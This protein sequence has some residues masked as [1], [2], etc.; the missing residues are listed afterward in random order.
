MPGFGRR[1]RRRRARPAGLAAL[2]CCGLIGAD[3][4]AFAV[5]AVSQ[6]PV[7]AVARP[8]VLITVVGAPEQL[9]RVRDALAEWR[10]GERTV[11]WQ[12]A[13]HFQP[14]ALFESHSEE[15]AVR[16]WV[17]LSRGR[18][19]R[20][21]FTN[22][23]TQRYLVRTLQTSGHLDE[24]DQEALGQA[25]ELSLLAILDDRDA[26][27]SRDDVQSLLEPT[28]APVE[29]VAAAEPVAAPQPTPAPLLPRWELGA[30]YAGGLWLDQ[31]PLAHG[32]G[33]YLGYAVVAEPRV[34][35]FV[36]GKQRLQN[37]WEQQLVRLGARSTA[38]TAG[39]EIAPRLFS[40][41]A[42]GAERL[43][44]RAAAGVELVWIRPQVGSFG[45]ETTLTAARERQAPLL[46]AA[47]ES[48]TV[49]P[50]DITLRLG[51]VAEVL[52]RATRY[53]VDV[54][55]QR[56]T[57]FRTPR[58]RPGAAFSVGVLLR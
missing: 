56:S 4:N 26:G 9:P 15:A 53:E 38:L 14:A 46:V 16:C 35:L 55:G 19:V 21:Y 34:S 25:I 41:G 50:S 48:L 40:L 36:S 6:R 13:D 49:L 54:E 20:L 28:P 44:L 32:P 57:V 30:A 47:L 3:L 24:M 37:T 29:P 7:H 23:V 12:S 39:A 22:G 33:L 52:P 2:L 31:A 51:I 58:V 1:G 17:D 27:V 45:S 11:S 8:D 10:L 18:S 5:E 42:D 43:A